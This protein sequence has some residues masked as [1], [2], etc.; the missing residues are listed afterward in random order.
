MPFV[1]K[2]IFAKT[3]TRA[4][5]FLMDE[6]IISQSDAQRLMAKGRLSKNGDVIYNS[7]DILEGEYQIIY[8]EPKP[9]GLEPIF[10]H[11][12]FAIYDKPTKVLVHPQNRY[13]EYCLN[14]EIK[15]SFGDIANVTH[16]IDFETSGL[17]IA[18]RNKECEIYFK[19][20]F[21]DRK[22]TKKYLAVVKGHLK[23]ELFIDEPLY[24]RD[25]SDA[26][27]RL[28]MLIDSRGKPS[29]T[30]IKPLE[31]FNNKD[32]TLVEATPITGRQ[33]QIRA[34]LFHVKHPIVGDTLYGLDETIARKYVERELCESDRAKYTGSDR[35]LL[36]ANYLE[37]DYKDKKYEIF[38]KTDFIDEAF[39]SIA[40]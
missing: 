13:T 9:R 5:R 24:R 4:F 40:F 26:L 34:H 3:P 17:V 21:Q 35:L 19:T 29:Q 33:H 2:N 23:N 38:S 16:R 18:S 1:V 22:I 27:V 37:F 7:S 12:D 11:N 32:I 15:Y 39:K 8:F 25:E 31:Y 36:H 30:I 20:S 6:L 10:I 14:D 28:M